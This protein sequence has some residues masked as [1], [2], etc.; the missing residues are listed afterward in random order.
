MK[1]LFKLYC[2][3]LKMGL[4]TFGGGYAMLPILQHEI[5][6]KRKWISKEELLNYYSIGQCTPGIIA[7]NTSSFVGYRKKGIL[8]LISATLGVISP[9]II[10]II[11]VAA[12]LQ[13]YMANQYIQWAFDGIRISVVALIVST[14]IDMWKSGVKNIRDYA[15]FAT[16]LFLLAVFNLSAVFIVI[17]AA[18][19]AFIL[20]HRKKEK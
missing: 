7:V 16:S 14:V 5:V 3:F 17:L 12:L 11:F 9:S 8:G 13:K 6:E 1:E 20:N 18:L 19:F 15:V 4:F 10:I 2:L